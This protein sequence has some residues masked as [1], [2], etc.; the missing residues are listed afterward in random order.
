MFQYLEYLKLRRY[1]LGTIKL[2]EKA[3]ARIGKFVDLTS[4]TNDGLRRFA[5]ERSKVVAVGTLNSDLAAA[6]SFFRWAARMGLLDDY[7][8]LVPRSRRAPARLVRY[9][10]ESEVGHLLAAPDLATPQGFRDHVMMRLA[11]ETGLRASEIIALDRGSVL[12]DGLIAV[13][14]GKGGVDR[15]VPIS[16]EMQQLLESWEHVRRSFR[17]GKRSVLFVNRYGRGFSSGQGLWEI[18]NRYARNALGRGRG[19]E[20]LVRTGQGKPWTGYYPHLLRASF[21]THLLHNGCDLRAVQDML[22]HVDIN[23]T[24][25]YLGADTEFLKAQH[26]KFFKHPKTKS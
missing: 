25:R 12:S 6:R 26:A 8:S 23:T 20:I 3:L 9:L 13:I 10:T 5:G 15:L 11:Y 18:V 14:G 22:G 7:Q 16:T 21:A 17:P 1:S 24:A 2:Y 19:F 4:P